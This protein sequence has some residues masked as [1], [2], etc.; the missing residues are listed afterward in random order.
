MQG[1]TLAE[2]AAAIDVDLT[3]ELS[4][5]RDTPPLGDVD[6]PIHLGDDAL[7]ELADWYDL[8]WRVI[9]R[10]TLDALAPSPIQLWPEHFD[11]SSLVAIGPG[12]DDRCDVGVSP[13]DHHHEEPYLYVAPWGPGRP[14][15]ETYWNAPFGALQPRSAVASAADAARFFREGLSRLVSSGDTYTDP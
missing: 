8:G 3:S 10:V 11:A 1:A 7:A 6:A 14:G 15:D 9:D 5:G 2:L 4:V 12:D 13:G